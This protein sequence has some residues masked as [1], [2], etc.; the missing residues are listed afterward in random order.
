ANAGELAGPLAH[1]FNNFLNIVLLH[2]A[3]LE[4]EIPENLRGDL[5]ELRRQGASMT[6]I[7]KQF[8]QYRRRQQSVQQPADVNRMVLAAAR[9]LAGS[10]ED[11]DQGLVIRL[12]PIYKIESPGLRPAAVPLELLLAPNLPLVL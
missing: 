2:I 9:S 6:S 7:V 11:S 3:L 12:P 1:E 10:P 5:T 4:A 8:Q